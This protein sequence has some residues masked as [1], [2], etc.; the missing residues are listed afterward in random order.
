MKELNR[1]QERKIKEFI[2]GQEKDLDEMQQHIYDMV[3]LHA[4][5]NAE[6]A[7]LL[8]SVMIQV[9]K[10]ENNREYLDK[11]DIKPDAL[12][13]KATLLIQEILAKEY[14]QSFSKK[15]SETR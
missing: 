15:D 7:A 2:S 3:T 14:A 10:G 8:T 12:G 5:T 6:V 1:F 9:L 13:L 4:L 11:L